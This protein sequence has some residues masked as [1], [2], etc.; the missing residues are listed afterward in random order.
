MTYFWE[1]EYESCA[2]EMRE[3]DSSCIPI[4]RSQY[5]ARLEQ[6][7]CSRRALLLS[8]WD[9][10]LLMGRALLTGLRLPNES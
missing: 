5:E 4:Y 7:F 2:C 3:L 6:W 8:D 9:F 10:A 1:A